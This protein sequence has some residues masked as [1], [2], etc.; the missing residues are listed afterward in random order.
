MNLRSL[1]LVEVR[2]ASGILDFRKEDEL[3]KVHPYLFSKQFFKIDELA[4]Y[5]SYNKP[6]LGPS[7]PAQAVDYLKSAGFSIRPKTW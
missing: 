1:Y 4:Y 6:N 7:S 2:D 5:V 3:R